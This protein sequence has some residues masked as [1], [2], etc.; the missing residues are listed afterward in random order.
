VFTY[1]PW[2]RYGV[3]GRFETLQVPWFYEKLAISQAYHFH[4]RS[5]KSLHRMLQKFY[6]SHWY[7]GRNKGSA[8]SLRDFIAENALREFG[9]STVEEAAKNFI[10]LEFAGCVPFS[11]DLCG[12]YPDIL[13][14]ALL[15]PP[16]RLV[17]REGKLV[18]RLESRRY[19]PAFVPEGSS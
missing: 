2:L 14:P 5:V 11:E 13:R 9:G 3:K 12:D 16:F 18:D 7:D 4:M 8:T 15:D 6:W 17:F 10:L 19:R 1:S